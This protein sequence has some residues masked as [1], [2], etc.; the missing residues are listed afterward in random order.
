MKRRNRTRT[1]RSLGAQRI[2]D[3]ATAGAMLDVIEA[4]RRAESMDATTDGSDRDPER[5]VEE[6]RLVAGERVRTFIDKVFGG[7]AVSVLR[8]G[9]DGVLCEYFLGRVS[10]RETVASLLV[11][12][13]TQSLGLPPRASASAATEGVWRNDHNGWVTNQITALTEEH[14][15]E[16]LVI[17]FKEQ[18]DSEARGR[19][20]HAQSR[21]PRQ[22][23]SQSSHRR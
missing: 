18:Q 23:R 4:W 2:V 22:R 20:A 17:A 5:G 10:D 21:T 15:I 1:R 12:E 13:L 7:R 16:R 14:A 11:P 19:R 6:E 3:K 9:A 8:S